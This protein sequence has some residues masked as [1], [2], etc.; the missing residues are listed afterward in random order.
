M[1]R[2]LITEHILQT[3]KKSQLYHFDENDS[4]ENLIDAVE[5]TSSEESDD[6]PNPT[7]PGSDDPNDGL[8]A[9]LIAYVVYSTICN[10]YLLYKVN[11]LKKK[12]ENHFGFLFSKGDFFSNSIFLPKKIPFGL[13]NLIHF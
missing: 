3:Q 13:F 9:G 8:M 6:Y 2:Q 11:K 1:F 4:E 7:K 5:D 10:L 12:K